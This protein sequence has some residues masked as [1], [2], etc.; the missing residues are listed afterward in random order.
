MNNCDRIIYVTFITKS[1]CLTECVCLLS[2]TVT[3]CITIYLKFVFYCL[4]QI[5]LK[6]SGLEQTHFRLNPVSSEETQFTHRT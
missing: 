1:I 3:L 2:S 5:I 4:H 6:L